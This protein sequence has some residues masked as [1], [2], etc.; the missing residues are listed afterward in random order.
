MHRATLAG[1]WIVVRQS[2]REGID[3]LI[4]IEP[5]RP[6]GSTAGYELKAATVTAS[7]STAIYWWQKR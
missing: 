4:P 1:N 3:H 5:E 2:A 6:D 7:G